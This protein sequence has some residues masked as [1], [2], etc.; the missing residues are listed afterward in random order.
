M[1]ST[2]AKVAS[3][4]GAVALTGSL[5]AA[6]LFS[7]A[8]NYA[9]GQLTA[10][11]SGANVSGGVWVSHSGTGALIPVVSGNLSYPGLAASTGN[12]ITHVHQATSAE[13][14]NATL[15]ST[16]TGTG[17]VVYYSA[18]F[19]PSAL[20]GAGDYMMHLADGANLSG[21]TTR[22][23]GRLQTKVGVG[24]GT[25]LFGIGAAGSAAAVTAYDT[26]DRPLNATYFVVVKV[27][28]GSS[29]VTGDKCDLFVNPVP[30][31]GEPGSPT[32]TVTSDATTVTPGFDRLCIRQ[33]S[34]NTQTDTVDEIR[35]GTTWADVA[36]VPAAVDN[37]SM[38]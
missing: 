21:G 35:V 37:W 30:G 34:T 4:L 15:S 27:T 5:S 31:L 17:S 28:L 11:S 22:F 26:V 36:P 3:L 24:S 14:I 18:L 10:T 19:N 32:V 23:Q 25:F 1:K 33:G 2:F 6:P 9:T 20:T 13:D 7:D 38:Y 8:F 29:G 16:V 12:S